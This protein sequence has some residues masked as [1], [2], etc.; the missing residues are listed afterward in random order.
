[1]RMP[2]E[3][4]KLR[5]DGHLGGIVRDFAAEQLALARRLLKEKHPSFENSR[6]P[7]APQ[8]VRDWSPC[9]NRES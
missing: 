2:A 9:R 1:M 8:P 3:V 7:Q 6:Q 5:T 4:S